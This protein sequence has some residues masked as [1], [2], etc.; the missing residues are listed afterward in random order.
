MGRAYR[1]GDRADAR[2]SWCMR[3]SGATVV[4]YGS[5]ERNDGG[6]SPG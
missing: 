4:T 2:V 5:D 6:A 3:R 1:C